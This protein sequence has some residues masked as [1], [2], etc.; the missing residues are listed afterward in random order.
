MAGP[1]SS[2]A[3]ALRQILVAVLAAICI[4]PSLLLIWWRASADILMNKARTPSEMKL[5]AG[6]DP[7]NDRY[8]VLLAQKLEEDGQSS[9]NAWRS[10][11]AANPRRDLSL[12]QAA[13]ASEISG[14]PGRAEQ[15]LLQAEQYNHLWLP[16][17]SLANF[18]ARH[19]RP[20]ETFRW[21][22]QA[23]LRSY[24][25]P[26][27]LFVLCR[28]AGASDSLLLDRIIP[29]TPAALGAFV[30]FLVRQNEPD[31]LEQAT[32]EYLKSARASGVDPL[33]TGAAAVTALIRANRPDPA[34]RLWR[35]LPLPYPAE[36]LTNPG[37]SR[38]LRP[39]AFDWQIHTVAG[40]ETLR[41]V[42][43]RGI[44]FTL[45]G[46]QPES[47]ELLAQDLYLPATGGWTLT[48][49]YETRGFTQPRSGLR[50]SLTGSESVQDLPLTDDWRTAS[51]T[52]VAAQGLHRLSLDLIRVTGQPRVEGELR[53]R[54]LRLKAGD[55]R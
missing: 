11:I 8:L 48:F 28:Q 10:A 2:S 9:V 36:V 7:L 35:S 16:R 13:I 39:P 6:R 50:W 42:P 55:A 27:A 47:A 17:W 5:A 24:S 22:H 37:L 38:P 19:N 51:A 12:T 29:A 30:Y 41:G 14:D 3:Y 20:V 54:N 26:S 21:A 43:N 32:A 18:Y 33:E 4:I 49:E 15:L 23:M 31:S 53:L 34:L 46:Q 40:V 25:D 44:K 1:T 52:W 45:S